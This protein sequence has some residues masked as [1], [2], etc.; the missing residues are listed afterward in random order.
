MLR[1]TAEN[2][3]A[4]PRMTVGTRDNQPRAN[5]CRDPVQLHVGIAALSGHPFGSDHTVAQQPGDDVFHR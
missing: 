3:F 4:K 5:F 2:P 1:H